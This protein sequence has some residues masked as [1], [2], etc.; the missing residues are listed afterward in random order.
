[1]TS[2]SSGK[3]S[4]HSVADEFASLSFDELLE[5]LEEIVQ[6]LETDQLPLEESI[7]TYE[8]G[9]KLAARCQ[10]LLDKAELRISQIAS[11]TGAT[12]PYRTAGFEPDDEE[13]E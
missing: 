1:M 2:P 10:L 3:Q 13:L 11:D 4:V 5:Q 6:Q 12:E 7:D 8:T 9:M